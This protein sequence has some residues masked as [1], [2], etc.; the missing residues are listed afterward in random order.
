MSQLGGALFTKTQQNVLGLLYSQPD[1]S[2]YTKEILRITGMGVSTIKNE[3]EKLLSAG[4]LKMEKIGNQ[5]HYQAN[6]ECPIYEELRS[7]VRKTFGIA[8]VIRQVLQTVEDDI[9]LAFIYGSIAKA[10]DTANSDID[11]LVV[12][13]IAHAELMDLL[14]PA[15]KT[16]RRDINP[17]IYTKA[18]VKSRIKQKN[19]FMLRILKQPKIWIKD[20]DDELKVFR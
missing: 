2:F 12:S 19:A 9:A 1:Q 18:Q 14:T 5:H 8:D 13:N 3:L 20:N 6:A 11:L 17:S 4:I 10:E 16:L 7:I 15:E